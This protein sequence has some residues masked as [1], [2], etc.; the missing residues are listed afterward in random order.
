MIK[1]T[2]RNELI[3]ANS[4]SRYSDE[5]LAMLKPFDKDK[6]A[7]NKVYVFNSLFEAGEFINKAYTELD[8]T[9]AAKERF[10]PWDRWEIDLDLFIVGGDLLYVILMYHIKF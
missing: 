6:W 8:F 9:K 1:L 4:K 5:E 10:H 2:I 7:D 3:P